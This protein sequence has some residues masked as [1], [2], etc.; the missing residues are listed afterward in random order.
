ML[1]DP[2]VCTSSSTCKEGSSLR[3]QPTPLFLGDTTPTTPTDQVLQGSQC[4][5]DTGLHGNHTDLQDRPGP[6]EALTEGYPAT[7]LGNSVFRPSSRLDHSGTPASSPCDTPL[8]ALPCTGPLRLSG[9]SGASQP[10][11]L[12]AVNRSPPRTAPGHPPEA[13]SQ[14]LAPRGSP[15]FS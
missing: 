8:S 5:Q 1:P 11:R 9:T 10:Q 15:D 6:W 4:L 14:D 12:P 7:G 13:A 2:Q 3:A